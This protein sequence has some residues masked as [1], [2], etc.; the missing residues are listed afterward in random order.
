MKQLR[1]EFPCTPALEIEEIGDPPRPL[2]RSAG[3]RVPL[4]GAGAEKF[5][6]CLSWEDIKALNELR[7]QET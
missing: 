5:I 2:G 3:I 1:I 7:L 6:L 4:T